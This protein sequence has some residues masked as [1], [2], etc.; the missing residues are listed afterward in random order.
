MRF[1]TKLRDGLSYLISWHLENVLAGWQWNCA[2]AGARYD[3][4]LTAAISGVAFDSRLLLDAEENCVHECGAWNRKNCHSSFVQRSFAQTYP[5]A[6]EASTDV[7][8]ALPNKIAWTLRMPN[9]VSSGWCSL[10][11]MIAS[12]KS[13]W[14]ECERSNP[15]RSVTYSGCW[16]ASWIPPWS[17]LTLAY[18][19]TFPRV[20]MWIDIR[21]QSESNWKSQ[22]NIT[23]TKIRVYSS[24]KSNLK[25]N[26][27]IF[28]AQKVIRN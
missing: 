17:C 15:R 1:P 11:S 27:L 14:W 13:R 8:S 12:A 16:H 21:I 25:A 26:K 19:W 6:A 2:S 9:A 4:F 28:H 24:K 22:I 20:L 3:D 5:T 23:M 10:A 18:P 7:L